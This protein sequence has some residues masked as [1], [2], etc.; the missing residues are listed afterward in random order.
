MVTQVPVKR[1]VG[2]GKQIEIVYTDGTSE[3]F[4]SPQDIT[5]P[6]V[7]SDFYLI[8]TELNTDVRILGMYIRKISITA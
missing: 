3:T 6:L 1:V 2:P 7:P 8:T 4:M 5:I